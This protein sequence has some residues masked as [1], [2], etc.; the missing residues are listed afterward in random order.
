ME[1]VQVLKT[2]MYRICWL[3]SSEAKVDALESHGKSHRDF[4]L[5][6]NILCIIY[7]LSGAGGKVCTGCCLLSLAAGLC[8]KSLGRR[9]G[10]GSPCWWPCS[11]LTVVVGRASQCPG[12][13]QL[14]ASSFSRVLW[15]LPGLGSDP[16][17]QEG[18]ICAEDFP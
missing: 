6:T 10:R 16:A 11:G 13:A 4:L 18:D 7:G 15:A 17:G 3:R 12:A 14:P 8:T 2:S 9:L 1:I 5:Y